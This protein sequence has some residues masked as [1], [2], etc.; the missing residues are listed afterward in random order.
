L[1]PPGADVGEHLEVPVRDGKTFFSEG[2]PSF[3]LCTFSHL[4]EQSYLPM[5]LSKSRFP[6]FSLPLMGRKDSEHFFPS[7]KASLRPPSFLGAN[8]DTLLSRFH[9]LFFLLLLFFCFSELH[10]DAHR[11]RPSSAPPVSPLSLLRYCPSGF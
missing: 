11:L 2:E 1:P 6:R 3:R 4:F 7:N 8:I 5:L 9:I 10:R